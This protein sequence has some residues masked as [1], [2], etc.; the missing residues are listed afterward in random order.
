MKEFIMKKLVTGLVLATAFAGSAG[1]VDKLTPTDVNAAMRAGDVV[2]VD[3]R[4]PDEWAANG[5]AKGAHPI[6][7]TSE[8]FADDVNSL[9]KSNKGKRLAF[10]CEAGVR[11][12]QLAHELEA[13]GFK[14]VVDVVG[15]MSGNSEGPGW[16]AEGLPVDQP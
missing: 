10:I 11:S 5:I 7:M 12:D 6:D 13:S 15:G 8:T 4:R 9:L 16:I 14:G 2:L 1:A 3:I